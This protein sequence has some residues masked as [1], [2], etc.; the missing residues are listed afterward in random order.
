FSFISLPHLCSLLFPYTTLFRS[1]GIRLKRSHA[2][3]V[4]VVITTTASLL[5][6]L[7]ADGF[8]GPFVSFISVLAVAISAWVGVFLV[9]MIRR[10]YYNEEALMDLSRSSGYWYTG[11]IR[12]RA[13]AP[14]LI[15]I[16]C[17]LLFMQ[18]TPGSIPVYTVPLFAT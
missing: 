1:L 13:F 4:D 9:D 3:I 11:G 16:V 8:Y 10:H 17:G 5:F 18:I 6:L 14:W 15:G 7:V 2:V 12:W